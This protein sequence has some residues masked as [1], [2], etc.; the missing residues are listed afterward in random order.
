MKHDPLATESGDT[1]PDPRAPDVI[2]LRQSVRAG[3]RAVIGEQAVILRVDVGRKVIRGSVNADVT[4]GALTI[5][6]AAVPLDIENHP[7]DHAAYRATAILV[8][9]EIA[10]PRGVSRVSL[11]ADARALAAFERALDLCRKPATPKPI[12]DHAVVEVLLWLDAIGLRLPEPGP[13]PM[14]GRVRALAAGNLARDW[15]AAEIARAL[16]TSEATLRRKLAAE[17]TGLAALL[18]DLRMSRAL[19]MLQATDMPVG[20]IAG[21]VGYASPSR[22]AVRFRAR[23]GVQP[24]AI[25]GDDRDGTAIDRLGTAAE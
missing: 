21:E 8:P 1:R 3:F 11:S 19:G 10:A 20:V 17:G 14:S 12:R 6:P 18:T 13:L 7:D 24:T 4:A 5:L 22:F 9:P 15:S 2:R 25:R 16:A 23:F